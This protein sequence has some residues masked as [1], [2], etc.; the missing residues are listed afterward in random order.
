VDGGEAIRVGDDGDDPT[1]DPAEGDAPVGPT[2]GVGV[3]EVRK[4]FGRNVAR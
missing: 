2:W 4:S 3:G 1:E